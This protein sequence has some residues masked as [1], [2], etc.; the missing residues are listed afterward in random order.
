MIIILEDLNRHVLLKQVQVN[1]LLNYPQLFIVVQVLLRIVQSHQ[2]FK[3]LLVT[4]STHFIR[5][6]F[7]QNQSQK[8]DHLSAIF[9]EVFTKPAGNHR[10]ENYHLFVIVFKVYNI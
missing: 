5:D 4:S 6:H 1:H 3:N 2:N 8:M 10:K 9:V 7:N